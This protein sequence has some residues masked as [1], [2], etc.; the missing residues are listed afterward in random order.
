MMSCAEFARLLERAAIKAHNELDIPTEALMVAVAAQAKEAIGTYTYGWPELAASTQADRVKKGYPADEP[1]LRTGALAASIEHR[2][3]L[4]P[5]GAEGL[6]FSED[7]IA[8]YQEMGT[9][10]GIPP[11]SFLFKSLWLAT[12]TMGRVFGAFA[13]KLLTFG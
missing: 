11:R 9:D 2:A 5:E 3:E 6:V 4:S 7:K 12:P 8:L 1:L 13:V 10:R